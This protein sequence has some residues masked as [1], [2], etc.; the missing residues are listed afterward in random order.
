MG[1]HERLKSLNEKRAKIIGAFCC[2][3]VTTISTFKVYLGALPCNDNDIRTTYLIELCAPAHFAARKYSLLGDP[4][5]FCNCVA[6]VVL[7]CKMYRER[8][9]GAVQWA[10]GHP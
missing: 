9:T 4:K 6:D 5:L 2:S 1:P 3:A 7:P 10:E 8:A